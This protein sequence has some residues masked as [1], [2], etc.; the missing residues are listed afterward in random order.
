MRTKTIQVEHVSNM[1]GNFL[2]NLCYESDDDVTR[3]A[4]SDRQKKC[5]VVKD[6]CSYTAGV[7]L[8]ANGL[9]VKL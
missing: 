1:H 7:P 6:G 2:I 4:A 8:L 9:S 3:Q 5:T